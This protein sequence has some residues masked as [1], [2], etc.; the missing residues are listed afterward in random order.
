MVMFFF[1]IANS[2]VIHA[3]VVLSLGELIIGVVTIVTMAS[4]QVSRQ[5]YLSYHD[6]NDA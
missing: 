4:L 3:D 5:P 2:Q 6:V 1:L